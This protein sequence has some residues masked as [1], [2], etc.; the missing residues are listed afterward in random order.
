ML[1]HF[2]NEK[3]FASSAYVFFKQLNCLTSLVKNKSS[4][5]VTIKQLLIDIWL[6]ISDAVIPQSKHF[7]TE[8]HFF[9]MLVLFVQCMS[10]DRNKLTNKESI[11]ATHS[12]NHQT[13]HSENHQADHLI[14]LVCNIYNCFDSSAEDYKYFIKIL[15]LT[16]DIKLLK[17]ILNSA[18]PKFEYVNNLDVCCKFHTFVLL[19]LIHEKFEDIAKLSISMHQVLQES[20]I[21]LY[22]DFIYKVNFFLFFIYMLFCYTL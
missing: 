22:L 13:D 17:F 9:E 5:D 16:L 6:V 7:P 21:M 14:N 11:D 1:R 8:D 4:S 10:T 19:P 3:I 2:F 20:E 18:V 15:C 12:E